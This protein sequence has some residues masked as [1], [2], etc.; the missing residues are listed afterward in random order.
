MLTYKYGHYFSESELLSMQKFAAN[1]PERNVQQ[2]GWS[3]SW[4]YMS[5]LLSLES[6][7][8]WQFYSSLVQLNG[9]DTAELERIINENRIIPEG[10]PEIYDP[11]HT[12]FKGI[13]K[14]IEL[15][16]L[17]Q[18]FG[19]DA[20]RNFRKLYTVND[21]IA[22]C[23]NND[24]NE[25]APIHSL[26]ANFKLESHYG[27]SLMAHGSKINIGSQIVS[28]VSALGEESLSQ[29]LNRLVDRFNHKIPIDFLERCIELYNKE[30]KPIDESLTSTIV[31]TQKKGN[32]RTIATFIALDPKPD[33][34]YDIYTEKDKMILLTLA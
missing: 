1:C 24:Y 5:I 25:L 16:D 2:L 8:E 22:I 21:A 7:K 13:S 26:I 14:R 23:G 11:S 6:H 15:L 4:K 18:F 30:Q 33:R 20:S 12:N 10:K 19:P 29:I 34:V 3:I 32:K 31:K 9:L 27:I 28:A 17:H